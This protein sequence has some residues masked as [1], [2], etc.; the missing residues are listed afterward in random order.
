MTTTVSAASRPDR[1]G[2]A[3][4]LPSRG[5]SWS[6][7][8]QYHYRIVTTAEHGTL[9][10][11]GSG[12]VRATDLNLFRYVGNDPQNLLDPLGLTAIAS[13]GGAQSFSARLTVELTQWAYCIRKTREEMDL[14]VTGDAIDHGLQSNP[15]L[16]I[17]WQAGYWLLFLARVIACKNKKYSTPPKL[18]SPPK[19]PD[20]P[21]PPPK[22]PRLGPP[23]RGGFPSRNPERIG[24]GNFTPRGGRNTSPGFRG[25]R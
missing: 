14:G 15:L 6:G 9:Y 19:P 21:A 16:A 18:P 12:R 7:T 10:Q 8:E 1:R 17:A 23:P 20:L 3:D 22:P 4:R 5:A 11:P 24:S 25:R 2:H 13:R